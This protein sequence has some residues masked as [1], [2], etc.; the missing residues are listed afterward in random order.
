MQEKTKLAIAGGILAV[1]AIFPL[2]ALAGADSEATETGTVTST[3]LHV[4][5]EP[6]VKGEILGDLKKGQTV[7]IVRKEKGWATIQFNGKTGYISLEH[8]RMAAGPALQLETDISTESATVT[9]ANVNVR[10]T[11]SVNGLID[12]KL[13]KGDTVRIVSKENGWARIEYSDSGKQG[14]VSLTYLK[15]ELISVSVTPAATAESGIVTA[16]K[17]NVR[18]AAS[19]NSDVIG[20]LKQG[21]KVKIVSKENSWA[22][23]EY[24]GKRGYVLLTY[25]KV[26]AAATEPTPTPAAESGTVT[27]TKLNIRQAASTNS[28]IIGSLKQGD[29]VKV[30][31]KTNGW[32]QIEYGGKQGYVLLTYLKVE[33]VTPAPTVEEGTVIATTL[34]VRQSASMG[35]AVIGTLKQGDKVK[36]IS[37]EKGWATIDYNGKSGY[38]S[39]AFVQIEDKGQE[40]PVLERGTVTATLLNVR[41]EASLKGAVVGTFKKGQTIDVLSK[42]GN[43]AVVEYN[44]SRAYVSLQYISFDQSE[45]PK[46]IE[47]RKVAIS[48]AE[49]KEKASYSSASIGILK[50]GE[51]VNVLAQEGDWVK[52]QYNN[53]EAYVQSLAFQS[54]NQEEYG[55]VTASV[56]NVRSAP[57]GSASIVGKL[58]KG[59]STV[60]IGKENN[61]AKLR[62]NGG[63]AYASLDYL[64]L[65]TSSVSYV[66]TTPSG[67]IIQS[68]WETA[69]QTFSSL[70]EDGY[71][72]R[73]GK[74]VDMKQGFVRT[75]GV[76]SIY[77]QETGKQLTYV[78]KNTDLQF[79]KST[80]D[81]AIVKVD[82]S[83]GYVSL[84]E[85]T[86]YPGMVQEPTSYYIVQGDKLFHKSYNPS[87]K[88]YYSYEVGYAPSH[89]HEGVK[90]EVFDKTTIGGKES[91]QYFQYVS[92]RSAADYTAQ[93]IDSFLKANRPDSPLIGKGASFVAAANKYHINVGY[94]L[95]HAILES[96]WGTSKI[97]R[98]KNNLFGF[99]AVDS[100]PYEGAASFETLEEGIDYCAGYIS[101]HYLMPAGAMY[102]GAILGDKS[103]GMNVLYASDSNW[104]Q[105]IASLMHKLD[106]KYGNRDLN[107]Y[108]LGMVQAN[109]ALWTTVGGEKAGSI[110]KGS[111]ITIKSSV[112]TKQGLYYE[113]VSDNSSYGTLYIEAKDTRLVTT[114]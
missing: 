5:A 14:Y 10:K 38:V 12:G 57:S 114:Y 82:G 25:L 66:I 104:S 59:D 23:I 31:S 65:E 77:S 113:I 85:V 46:V 110:S 7:T 26:E 64:S 58:K 100:N 63:E 83:I 71:V 102:N 50:Q 47:Q 44:G 96:A 51:L 92:L 56:L 2:Q 107:I 28:A 74:V 32:A 18:Q 81:R 8:V 87:S 9:A 108:K 69:S 40:P 48:E 68:S 97:A 24:S 111:M 91:Y 1:T 61:W 41:K 73:N 35:A 84:Q 22:Q 112:E 70:T 3:S 109:A 78:A 27:A 55:T 94:L 17:L 21:E 19:T 88:T 103:R 99:Q 15:T 42:E 79:V 16:T 6:S 29:Q 86:L 13:K 37:K 101:E 76:V 98:E 34:N 89:L 49:V 11:P 43:W 52:I 36:V 75:N 105:Q 39:L 106:K 72:T 60:V 53:Q 20:S 33:A 90:Y 95:S 30:I 80:G 45:P 54:P 67:K 93:E 4:R 62:F